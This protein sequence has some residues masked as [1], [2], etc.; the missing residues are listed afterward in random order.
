M[1][2]FLLNDFE[3]ELVKLEPEVQ[4]AVL[5]CVHLIGSNVSQYATKKIMEGIKKVEGEIHG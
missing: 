4:K 5:F 1:W 2:N 3:R